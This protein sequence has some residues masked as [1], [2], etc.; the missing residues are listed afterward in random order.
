MCD[1]H[2]H[3]DIIQATVT[4]AYVQ[5][6]KEGVRVAKCA[7]ASNEPVIET[8]KQQRDKEQTTNKQ[9]ANNE[10]ATNKYQLAGCQGGKQL[11]RGNDRYCPRQML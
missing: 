5:D 3:T 7:V 6:P 1:P 2:S 10:Q 11:R 9:Q 4:I 8:N